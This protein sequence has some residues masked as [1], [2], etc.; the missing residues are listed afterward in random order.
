M[1]TLSDENI[2]EQTGMYLFSSGTTGCP[3]AVELTQCTIVE[4][5][6]MIRYSGCFVI[7]HDQRH[8]L[9]LYPATYRVVFVPNNVTCWF[10]TQQRLVLALYPATSR[11]GFVPSNDSCCFLPG[12]DSCWFCTRQR[13]MLALYP[14]T[15][16][17]GF[18][19][20]NVSYWLCTQ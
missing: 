1:P 6:G 13:H 15:F 3:K 4:A 5:A 18:V 11:V 16:R 7:T 9:V 20:S 19:R 12:N 8:V 10:C 2:W 14:A 17:S